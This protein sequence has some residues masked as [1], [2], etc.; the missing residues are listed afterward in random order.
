[1]I[2]RKIQTSKINQS[3]HMSKN[4]FIKQ[5]FTNFHE[6]TEI[7]THWDV[8][9]RQLEPSVVND[10]VTLLKAKDIYLGQFQFT[11]KTHQK[12]E[13]PPGRT[14]VFHCG[15]DSNI[16]WRNKDVS[17]DSL[18]ICPI[19]AKL[20]AVTKGTPA[21]PHAITLPEELMLS[22]LQNK[23][24]EYYKELV[25]AHDLIPVD[26]NKIKTVKDIFDKYMEGAEEDP[27][28]IESNNY[29]SCL[30]EELISALIEA[31]FSYES[32]NS[33]D[34]DTALS[35][36][37]EKL[38]NYMETHKD[39]PFKVSELSQAIAVSESTLNRLFNA[40]F[41][42]SPK[43]YLIKLRLNAVYQDL[44]QS[45][46]DKIKIYM[47]AN[48]WGFWHMGQFAADYRKLFGELPME[49]LDKSYD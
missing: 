32:Y 13:F 31:L 40:K 25:A 20:D 44:K 45:S 35:S 23:E 37:W 43:S 38:E 27:K 29:Q 15:E 42:I 36:I 8:E 5:T 41:G 49:T 34:T 3:K 48:K 47:I 16:R 19:G 26:P 30:E 22:R 18:M 33:P 17:S 28:L 1:M 7:L 46:P 24:Q 11:G 2:R 9:I 10:T 4:F 12:G 14:F 39:K 6:M 21:S